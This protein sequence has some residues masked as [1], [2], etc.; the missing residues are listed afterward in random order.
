[1]VG[2]LPKLRV[3]D[4][5]RHEALSVFPLFWESKSTIEY[6]ISDEALA[7]QSV[8]VEEVSEGGSVPDLVVENRGDVR[9]LFLEGEQL[10]GAKQ[11]RILNTSVLIGAHTKVKIPV[12]CVEQGRWR[13][14]ARHFSSSGSHAQGSLRHA[15]KKSVSMSVSTTGGHSSDQGAI[16]H[17]VACLQAFHDVKSETG[18]LS[19]AFEQHQGVIESYR[20][21]LKYPANASGMAVAIG[22]RVTC[23]DVF[24]K[25][26]TCEKVWNRLLSG[27][28]FAVLGE[29]FDNYATAADVERLL[30]SASEFQWQLSPAV[31]E[32]QEFRA[33]SADGYASALQFDG[34]TIHGNVL[35]A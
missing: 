8:V 27:Y 20:E 10:I 3:G 4:P 5:I 17:E 32:G 2:M 24:D 16:W 19:D 13:Y 14:T 22:P 29:K 30:A 25:P 9:V 23:I 21:K 18:A 33:E 6:R 31:G 34:A 12:S 7:D 15:L 11:N 28:V 35:V 1:M 26:S